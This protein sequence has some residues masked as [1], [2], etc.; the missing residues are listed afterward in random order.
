[1][2]KQKARDVALLVLKEVDEKAAY[3]NIVLDRMLETKELDKL[4]RAFATELVY[5]TLR[6]L[7]TVDWFLEQV[8]KRP[9][10]KQTAWLRNILRLG[11]YQICFL[12]KV[13]PSAA[14]NEAA[15]QARH[16]TNPGAVKFANGVLR[17]LVRKREG[18]A[19]PDP[20]ENPVAYIALSC[21]HPVWLIQQ[22]LETYGYEETLALC[23]ANNMAA[24][25][26]VRTNTLRITREQLR[27][28]LAEEGIWA[29][30]T[31]YAPE[32]LQIG[33]YLS[34]RSC[35]AFRQGLFQ[36]QDESS[37]LAS[38]AL[39][40][41]PRARVLDAAAAPGGKSTHLAQLMQ[42]QGM[43]WAVDVHAHK[44]SLIQENCQRL[45]IKCI[46]TMAM[47]AT[48]LPDHMNETIDFALVD[49]PCSGL[50][51]LRRRP[52][53]RWRKEPGQI[54]ALV[55]LQRRILHR[56]A[57][58]VKPGGILVYSTCTLTKEEN[59]EQVEH[60][61]HEHRQFKGDDL[62]SLLPL[63]LDQDNTMQQG[64]VQLMPHRHGMDGFFIA[65]LRKKGLV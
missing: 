42:N 54:A 56:V 32:G 29:Q 50:G 23:Q 12:D 15:N 27:E 65:R 17:N 64:Y 5:G 9:L 60:F 37:M 10:A 8:L 48:V 51:V 28:Q 36:V 52:D 16:F 4:E 45:G 33:G 40:P 63:E 62:R 44:L 39:S 3:A 57:S 58:C 46:Q 18:I 7:N 6:R 34:L 59:Q 61:L 30:P 14:V 35:Q 38:R 13:P 21:S 26:T 11:A 55:Q 19:Y 25:L 43:L 22:W 31:T 53:A 24:P 20:M 2:A 49:A 1:M 41:M 47:D